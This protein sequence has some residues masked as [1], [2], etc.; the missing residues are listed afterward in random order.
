MQSIGVEKEIN[1]DSVALLD[2]ATPA[3]PAHGSLV[4]AY[5]IAVVLGLLASLGVLL[6]VDRLDDRPASFTDLQDMFDEPVLGQIPYEAPRPGERGGL[7][8]LHADDDRHAFLEAYRNLRSSLLYMATQGQRPRVLVV[9][10]AIPGDGKSMTTANLAITMALAGSR[11]LLVDADLR[12]GLL[13]R[14]FGVEGSTGL[15][16]VLT[17]RVPTAQ[18]IVTT[19]T[20]NLF[21]LPRGD[22]ARNPGEMFLKSSTRD[23]IKEL[24]AQFDYVIFDTAPVMAAD[25][26]TSLAP[27]VEGVLFVIRAGFTSGRVARAALDL[28]YQREVAVLGLVFNG[29]QSDAGEYYYYRY[30]DYY[31]ARRG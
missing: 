9:T 14:R 27:H 28:L 22:T 11:V 7:A 2:K 20:S 4:K 30:K 5:I 29:V 25:D 26:V 1:P 6:L 19:T 18:A 21:L 8:L 16:E 12:K 17:G 24:A 31:A 3:I 23:L 15:T 10:S 13:H